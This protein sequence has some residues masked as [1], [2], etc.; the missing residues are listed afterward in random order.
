M[1]LAAAVLIGAAA[2]VAGSSVPVH[3][4][5]WSYDRLYSSGWSARAPIEA[6]ARGSEGN[7]IGELEDLV[8]NP[9]RTLVGIIVES[10]GVLDEIGETE[11]GVPWREVKIGDDMSAVSVPVNKENTDDFNVEDLIPFGAEDEPAETAEVKPD[12]WGRPS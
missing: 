7:T 5:D 9:D 4:A 12:R 1:R 6:E 8:V 10:G 11:F 2:M 3:A